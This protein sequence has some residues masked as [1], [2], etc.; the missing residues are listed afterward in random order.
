MRISYSFS[1][2]PLD[3]RGSLLIYLW[4]MEDTRGAHMMGEL[5]RPWSGRAIMLLDL[6]AFFASVEQLDHPEW[7]G[8]P[9]IVGGDADRHGVVSTCSYEARAF[10]VHSAM[11][12]ATAA[13]LCPDAIWTHG[14]HERYRQLSAQIMDMI[15][16]ETPY[17]EQVSIDEAFADITPTRV[18]TEHPVSVVQ[19]I[20]RRVF[21]E[22]GVTCSIGLGPTK[23]VAK[24][25]SDMEKPQG[26]TI[27]YPGTERAFLAPLP[28]GAL[29]GV[30][31]AAKEQLTS[32]GVRT[33]GELAAAPELVLQKVFGQ[34]AE[35]MRQRAAAEDDSEISL[36]RP[37]KS[38]S[39]EATFSDLLV[40]RADIHGAL[41]TL[42]GKVARRLRR[43]GLRA[44]TLAVK[45]RLEDRSVR[46]GQMGLSQPSDD[47]IELAVY[48]DELLDKVWR[49]GERVRLLGVRASGFTTKG[50]E[51]LQGSLFDPLQVEAGEVEKKPLI[52]DADKRKGLLAATDALKDRFGE[53][54]VIFGSA[55][56]IQGNDTGS[57]SKHPAHR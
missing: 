1:G 55:L 10:G 7:R 34:R 56:R 42:L 2:E 26:L 49:D 52:V 51:E 21:E 22:A 27:V 5:L 32:H 35:M 43:K 47:E 11:A 15:R 48:L 53:D 8:K 6:D 13:R 44:R 41:V 36:G 33:L 12:S 38:V 28:I 9:V 17:V 45:V 4:A 18:N 50:I 20:Q 29:S 57:S 23:S 3:A 46:N 24:T 37:V 30:G 19:R 40:G 16:D 54:A 14:R 39:H 31:A 25:A